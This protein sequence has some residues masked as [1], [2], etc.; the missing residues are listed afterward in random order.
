[1]FAAE[2]TGAWADRVF[3]DGHW[4]F[5]TADAGWRSLHYIAGGHFYAIGNVV[6][7]PGPETDRR[8]D[9]VVCLPPT[10]LLLGMRPVSLGNSRAKWLAE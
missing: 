4:Q 7:V 8:R 5:E 10:V 9:S 6:D 1:M 2:V 3:R